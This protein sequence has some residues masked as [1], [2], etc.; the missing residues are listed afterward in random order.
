MALHWLHRLRRCTAST[1]T[2]NTERPCYQFTELGYPQHEQPFGEM[3][4]GRCS[5]FAESIWSSRA[6]HGLVLVF[7]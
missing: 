6:H 7:F 2:I 5:P 1:G 3:I 4:G